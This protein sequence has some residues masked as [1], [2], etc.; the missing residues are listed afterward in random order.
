MKTPDWIPAMHIC[1]VKMVQRPYQL[2]RSLKYL[3]HQNVSRIPS[4]HNPELSLM[5]RKA[6]KSYIMLAVYI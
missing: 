4:N 1:Q 5:P 6:I 2:S 3:F